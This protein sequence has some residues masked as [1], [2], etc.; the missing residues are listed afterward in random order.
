MYNLKTLI[1][2]A[3]KFWEWLREPNSFTMGIPA[4]M[5]LTSS[6]APARASDLFDSFPGAYTSFGA[7]PAF[8][9]EASFGAI[10]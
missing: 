6:Q 10:N 3:F 1:D 8:G 4:G 2:R 7:R 9:L 5:L